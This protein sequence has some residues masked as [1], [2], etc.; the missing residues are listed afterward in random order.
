[1]LKGN[2]MAIS[3]TPDHIRFVRVHAYQRRKDLALENAVHQ[4]RFSQLWNSYLGWIFLVY[5]RSGLSAAPLS[6][7]PCD[8]S[9]RDWRG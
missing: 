5:F 1:M 8:P 3:I 7:L 9:S 4:P 6:D 2:M